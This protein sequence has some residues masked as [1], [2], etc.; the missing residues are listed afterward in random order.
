MKR[1]TIF[2]IITIS[3][4]VI[5]AGLIAEIGFRV[6]LNYSFHSLDDISVGK[7]QPV[8]TPNTELTLGQVIQLSSNKN[9]VYDLI[10]SS[11]YTFQKVKVQ[12]N[13]LSLIHI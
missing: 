6:Y 13:K 8:N 11:S 12:T 3:I 4:G 1:Q 7:R 10:P 9:I 5:L 2:K